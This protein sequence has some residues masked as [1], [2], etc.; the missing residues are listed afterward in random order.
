MLA[1]AHNTHAPTLMWGII[2]VVV[3]VIHLVFRRYYARR[4]AAVQSA[5][6]D[7]APGPF[8]RLTFGTNEDTNLVRGTILSAAFVAVGLVLIVVSLS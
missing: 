7:T 1:T 3:G 6:R 8:K 5:R 4:T 2:L